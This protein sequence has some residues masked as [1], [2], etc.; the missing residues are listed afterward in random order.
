MEILFISLLGPQHKK[1]KKIFNCGVPVLNEYIKTFAGQDIKR[2]LS[3]CFV[4]ENEGHN[5]IGYYTISNDGIP[6]AQLPEDFVKKL[7]YNSLPV[8]LL[9]RLAVDISY[10]GK[11]YGEMLLMDALKKCYVNRNVIASAAIV[12]DPIDENAIKFYSKY[13]FILLPDSSRMFLAM[14]TLEKLFKT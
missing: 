10:K 8:T 4:L 5:I 12:V 2:N 7:P 3:A 11:G 1:S 13:G 9:G 14:E 6:K